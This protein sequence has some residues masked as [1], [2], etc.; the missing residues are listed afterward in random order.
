M[1]QVA[2]H[3]RR[4]RPRRGAAGAVVL[5]RRLCLRCHW[6][7]RRLLQPKLEPA[8][9]LHRELQP[10]CRRQVAQVELRPRVPPHPHVVDVERIDKSRLAD[11]RLVT[12]GAAHKSWLIPRRCGEAPRQLRHPLVGGGEVL[13]GLLLLHGRNRADEVLVRVHVLKDVRVPINRDQLVRNVLGNGAR[14]HLNGTPT[15]DHGLCPGRRGLCRGIGL[16]ERVAQRCQTRLLEERKQLLSVAHAFE[17]CG[18]RCVGCTGYVEHRGV[19]SH[20]KLGSIA[21]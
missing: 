10:G 4:D 9:G 2:D 19:S 18:H 8:G 11:V 5:C 15:T 13:R 12:V 17:G 1:W 6:R 14:L 7:R 20:C 16:Q 3:E 21:A